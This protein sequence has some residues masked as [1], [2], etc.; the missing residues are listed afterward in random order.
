M[1]LN[2]K[3]KPPKPRG[4]WWIGWALWLVMFAI[5]E[6]MALLDPRSGDTLSEHVWWVLQAPVLW[7]VGAGFMVWLTIHFLTRGKV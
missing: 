3:K 5:L 1:I 6:T 4:K 7:F 2:T